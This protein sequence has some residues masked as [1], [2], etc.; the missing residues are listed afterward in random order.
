MAIQS[1]RPIARGREAIARGITR[2]GGTL[3]LTPYAYSSSDS[4][5]YVVGGYRYPET[6]GPGGRFVLA[7]RMAPDG[8]WLIAADLDNSGPRQ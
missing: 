4:V 8:R 7:L 6:T 1:G 2:P 5:G 3:Q